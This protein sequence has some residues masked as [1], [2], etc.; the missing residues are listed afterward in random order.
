MA[1]INS[2][3]FKDITLQ[4]LSDK[5]YVLRFP[6]S[7]ADILLFVAERASQVLDEYS[8]A[9]TAA[10]KILKAFYRVWHISPMHKLKGYG[11]Y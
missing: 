2:E 1:F 11:M 7:N 10:L 6:R 4:C 3:L 5:Q 9:R 8:E